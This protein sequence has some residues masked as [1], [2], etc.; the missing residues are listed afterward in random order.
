MPS[1]QSFTHL[2]QP[3]PTNLTA[4][5]N[6]KNL[7]AGT[8]YSGV[9]VLGSW[10]WS[11]RFKISFASSGNRAEGLPIPTM[12]TPPS[13]IAEAIPERD[14][15]PPTSKSF[16]FDDSGIIDRHLEAKEMKKASRFWVDG[17]IEALG[18]EAASEEAVV[19][20]P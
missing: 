15:N 3:A 14:L 10:S 13:L 12:S 7:F 9:F 4:P 19:F 11:S 6:L 20:F 8:W 17:L 18:S 5:N 16:I 2:F 1:E